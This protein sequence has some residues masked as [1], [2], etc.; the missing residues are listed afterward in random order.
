MATAKPT[1]EERRLRALDIVRGSSR[2]TLIG[3]L[4]LAM[5]CSLAEAEKLLLDLVDV[6]AIRH[7][8]AAER[9]RYDIREGFLPV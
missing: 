5:N 2:P 9:D 6:G 4:A 3:N 8:T 1:P 7:A